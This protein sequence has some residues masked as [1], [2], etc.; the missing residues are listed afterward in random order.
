[1]AAARFV[2]H[3][4]PRSRSDRI[5]WLLEEAGAAYEIARHDLEQGTQKAATYLAVNPFGKVPALVDRGPDGTWQDVA[6]TESLAI[7]AYVADVLP[8]ARLAPAPNTPARAAYATWMATAAAV[9]EPA[10]V[11]L[12]FPRADPAP[13]MALG[14]P[15]AEV[16]QAALEARLGQVPFVAGEDFSAADIMVGGLMQW[17]VG[18]G[19]ATPGPHLVRYLA[20]I[21][22]RPALARAKAA[23]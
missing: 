22:A 21:A 9:L 7:C 5:L 14:W 18:W 11:D 10:F 12:A 8:D 20:G 13:A 19:K 2:L 1:M 4:A 17:L 16:A 23:S 3:H 6:V 15:S